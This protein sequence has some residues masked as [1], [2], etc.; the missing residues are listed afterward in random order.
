MLDHRDF[1]KGSRAQWI[2]CIMCIFKCYISILRNRNMNIN[3]KDYIDGVKNPLW[4]V[5]ATGWIPE[6]LFGKEQM[7]A[8]CA[9]WILCS[10][11]TCRIKVG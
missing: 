1:F 3:E 10:T 5:V 7:D 11:L 9:Q 8:V 4:R 6:K 2:S